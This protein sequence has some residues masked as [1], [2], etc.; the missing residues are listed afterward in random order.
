MK[1]KSSIVFAALLLIWCMGVVY[2]VAA[3]VANGPDLTGISVSGPSTAIAGKSISLSATVRNI[4]TASAGP[5][6]VYFYLSQDTSITTGDVNLGRMYLTSLSPGSQKTVVLSAKIPVL[7]PPGSY[8][9]GAITDGSTA[10]T[11]EINNAICSAASTRISEPPRPDLVTTSVGSPL[12]GI[13][14]KSIALNAS[15]KNTGSVSA[16]YFYVSFYLSKDM[17][18]DPGDILIGEAYVSS[19]SAGSSRIVSLSAAIPSE[20]IDGTYYI[21][22]LADGTGRISE[23]NE[24]NNAQSS[25]IL[26]IRAGTATPPP[27]TGSPKPDLII[28]G[29]TA[30]STASLGSSIPVSATVK[31]AGSASASYSYL[32]FYLSSD[33]ILDP[34]DSYLGQ[35]YVSSL[36]AGDTKSVSSTVTIPAAAGEGPYYVCARADATYLVAESNESN[37]EASVTGIISITPAPGGTFID[38]V[39]AA[40]VTYTNQERTNAGQP[41]LTRSPTLAALARSHSQDMAARNFWGHTNPDGL[42][43]FERMEVAGYSYWCA[44]ENI[45]YTSSFTLTSNPDEVGRYFVQ[46]MWMKSSGHRAN[47]LNNCVTEI[48]VGIAYE[49]DRSASPY[50]VIATQDF[51]KPR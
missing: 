32:Y 2:P 14:G 44:A 19:L 26:T 25:G 29:V 27:T 42:D 45:G 9:Y 12:A 6:Y 48:G 49:P 30:P 16:S 43:P 33:S 24:S 5:S 22:A 23:Q 21:C 11:N 4:G 37:N 47:I 20:T 41:A 51:G 40:I 35:S 39:E 8:Y 17:T 28:T 38:Q 1:R 3:A 31:N 34:G 46:E 50:G 10:E 18:I 36:L 13:S 15:V 7:T